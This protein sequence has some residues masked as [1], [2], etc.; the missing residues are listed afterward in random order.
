MLLMQ[1][2][3]GVSGRIAWTLLSQKSL[4]ERKILGDNEVESG[5]DRYGS[6]L[7]RI[8]YVFHLEHGTTLRKNLFSSTEFREGLLSSALIGIKFGQ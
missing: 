3:N 1:M 4:F 2:Q 8:T 7:G 6:L 5:L